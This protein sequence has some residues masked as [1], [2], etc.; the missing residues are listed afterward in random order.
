M[1]KYKLSISRFIFELFIVFIGVYG[2]FE[3]TNYQQNVREEKIRE[4]YFVSFKSELNTLIFNI[5][6]VEKGISKELY[7]LENYNDSLES[8]PF[9]PVR[10]NFNQ[11]LLITQ[12]GFNADVFVQL[13]PD[14]ASSLIGGFDY[15]KRLEAMS[16]DYNSLAS[17]KLY[18]HKWGDLFTSNREMKDEFAWYKSQL[19]SMAKN[20]SFVGNMMETQATPFINQVIEG[21]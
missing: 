20:F 2:A 3:L 6:Q 13:N 11:S 18:G 17:L 8:R 15:V 10:I 19:E 14:L 12:A 7:R 1:K 21:F 5:D 16:D 4:N 9:T